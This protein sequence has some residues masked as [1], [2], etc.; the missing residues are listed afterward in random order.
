MSDFIYDVIKTKIFKDNYHYY[1]YF[2]VSIIKY[3]LKKML[4]Y[5][6]KLIQTNVFQNSNVINAINEI[7]VSLKIYEMRKIIQATG[8]KNKVFN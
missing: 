1:Y 6:E 4:E 5:D 2:I 7:I 8:N 3:R